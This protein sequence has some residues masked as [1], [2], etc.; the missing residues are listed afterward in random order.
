MLCVIL[1]RMLQL[2][3]RLP[4]QAFSM[5]FEMAA[6][7][8]ALTVFHN[9]SIDGCFYHLTQS[10]WRK[11]QELGLAGRHNMDP[12]FKNFCGQLDSLAFLPLNDV[13]L[14]M[15]TIRNIVLINNEP[16]DVMRLLDYFDKNLREWTR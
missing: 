11:I 12:P 16:I 15:N 7:N 6:N 2:D 14:G 8:A 1:N 3:V 4:M 13:Q 9:R 5:D 10:T